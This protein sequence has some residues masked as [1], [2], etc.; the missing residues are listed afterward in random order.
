[1]Q[2]HSIYMSHFH[3]A[4]RR[5]V[6]AAVACMCAILIAS[7]HTSKHVQLTVSAAA[8]LS[9]TIETIEGG[10]AKQHPEVEFRNNFGSSGAL[11]RQIEQGAPVDLFLSAGAKPVDEL[12]AKGLVGNEQSHILLRNR[13]AL[14]TP[15]D[16][17]LSS[18]AQLSAKQV[19]KIALGEPASVPAGQYAMQSLQAAGIFDSLRAKFVYAKDVRQVLAYVE[20]G[21]V[22][23]G[24]VYAT[25]ARNNTKVKVVE[26]LSE[27]SHDPIVYPVAVIARGPRAAAARAFADYLSSADASAIFTGKGFIV[28]AH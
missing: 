13:L 11:A 24:F 28:A 5:A 14:I 21:N 20:S 6:F 3:H 15:P 17:A 27:V 10:Y 25:D 9:G 18:V 22:D 26:T 19:K 4:G 2:P 12:K 1:M 23:A 7:C 16:S 8:S